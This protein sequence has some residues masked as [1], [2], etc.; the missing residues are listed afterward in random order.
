MRRAYAPRVGSLWAHSPPQSALWCGAPII[1]P[2][3]DM[4]LKSCATWGR[5]AESWARR[6][7]GERLTNDLRHHSKVGELDGTAAGE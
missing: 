1:V 6:G 3:L 7:E 4:V 2:R 5:T